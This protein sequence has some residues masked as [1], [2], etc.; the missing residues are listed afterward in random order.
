M[1][2]F[3]RVVV[4]MAVVSS[5]V[6]VA[7]A[8]EPPAKG[9]K[10]EFYWG[11]GKAVTGLTEDK[12]IVVS[13]EGHRLYLHKQPV[14]TNKD[15]VKVEVTKT[16]F[17]GNL[18]EQFTVKFHLTKEARKRLAE[19]CGPSGDKMLKAMIDGQ[20]Y[21]APYYLKSR[22]EDTFVPFA[23]MFSSKELA[24][25]IVA[26]FAKPAQ[27]SN[28]AAPQS[29][30]PPAAKP[31]MKIEF[32]WTEFKHVTGV[33]E[34]KGISSGEGGTSLTYLHKQAALTNADI[35]EAR[36][37][38]GFVWEING[39]K[40]ELRCVKLNLTKEGKQKL[41]KSG[42]PGTK[43]SLALLVD[44]QC[45]SSFFVDV[46]DLTTFVHPV[47]FYEQKEADEL[48]A[49]INASIAVAHANGRANKPRI[50][51]ELHW[52]EFKHEPGVT[53]EKG[54]PFGEGD[55]AP[56]YLHKQA[57]LSIEDIADA[58]VGNQFEFA[59]QKQ[60]PVNLFLT[61]EGQQKLEKTG[62]S[63]K[64]KLLCSV[65]DGR[66][67]GAA[68]YVNFKEL[69]KFSYFLAAHPKAEA[70]S[71]AAS[72]NA[73]AE[74]ARQE[75]AASNAT[76]LAPITAEN[77]KDVRRVSEL[78]KRVHRIVLGPGRGEVSLFDYG[79]PV[80]VVEDVNLRPLR[81]LVEKPV[82]YDFALSRDGR[83]ATWQSG[84]EGGYVVQALPS[85]E[86]VE[87]KL[88]NSP[89]FA[90]FSPDGQWLAIGE[91]FW[92]P[93]AE[94]EGNS[95]VK[96]F[97]RSG[98][99]V[100][101]IVSSG[102]GAI[103]PVFSPDGK[104]LAIGNRNYETRLFDVQS[105]KHLHTL[106]RL[107]THGIAFSPDGKLLA[108][109]YVDGAVVLWNVSN[110]TERQSMRNVATE[111][112]TVDWSPQGDVLVTAGRGGKITL[113]DPTRMA[114]LKEL[115]SPGWVVSARFTSDGTRLITSGGSDYG[116]TERK[117]VIWSAPDNADQ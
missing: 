107:M 39:Q 19:T 101:T 16:D 35:A 18:K 90:G 52:A 105:G 24:D 110:G 20:S 106:P 4:A 78:E 48:A 25:R 86:K 9:A 59:G 17:G 116:R 74:E 102:P 49:G 88:E 87:I 32:R 100:R 15:V 92:E 14:L 77:A 62:V 60:H 67:N 95:K 41:A 114:V 81:T 40:I 70:E 7:F 66:H 104:T 76:K 37:E 96:L 33:T 93:K 46:A 44:G 69:S 72:I 31:G 34:D 91:T 36:V 80:E 47:G 112:Y 85:G 68:F 45:T 83:Y 51:V 10:V 57:V 22:D 113:W 13:E 82:A 12:G 97:D 71:L 75:K 55:A 111:I 3:N 30:A 117:V 79:Q 99:H 108:A 50:K 6:E 64:S 61:N 94:G 26:T 63:V 27:D 84:R 21:G 23:G 38:E 109:G 43:Q 42:K 73:A 65:I 53:D 29:K 8:E 103:T 11:E 2:W 28:E 54:F 89:G 5:V 58:R 56:Y 98:K 1:A 115:D